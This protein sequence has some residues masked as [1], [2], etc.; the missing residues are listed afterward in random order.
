MLLAWPTQVIG[1]YMGATKV[2]LVIGGN[3]G[4]ESEICRDFRK[5]ELID[6]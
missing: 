1:I 2:L 4:M 3:H 6:W 5:R